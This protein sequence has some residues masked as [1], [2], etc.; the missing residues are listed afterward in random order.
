[1][2][3]VSAR[4]ACRSHVARHCVLGVR[5]GGGRA[6]CIAFTLYGIAF[7]R[8]TSTSLIGAGGGL[9]RYPRNGGRAAT[10]L[11][12]RWRRG[13]RAVGVKAHGVRWSHV[14]WHCV[15]SVGFCVPHPGRRQREPALRHGRAA[16]AT[17]AARLRCAGYGVGVVGK[18]NRVWPDHLAGYCSIGVSGHRLC[19]RRTWR[20]GT[21]AAM[22]QARGDPAR[23]IC[24][25]S[26][27]V[28]GGCLGQLSLWSG[29]CPLHRHAP[30]LR[31]DRHT[32]DLT[33]RPA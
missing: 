25:K 18:Q 8:R 9:E 16:P 10:I 11:A 2:P 21:H 20:S 6:E 29:L 23:C 32:D 26:P 13:G 22:Q 12:V 30:H 1:V 4:G 19:R 33:E 24:P 28:S 31:R 17:G 15:R 14:E 7:G 27:R 5:I 3:V